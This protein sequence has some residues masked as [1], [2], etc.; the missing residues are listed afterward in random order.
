MRIENFRA[1]EASFFRRLVLAAP[2]IIW[3]IQCSLLALSGEDVVLSSALILSWCASVVFAI[4]ALMTSV[5]VIDKPTTSL[6]RTDTIA[7]GVAFLLTSLATMA[8]LYCAFEIYNE[9]GVPLILLP[10][11]ENIR[12]Q[13][14]PINKYANFL[15]SFWFIALPMCMLLRRSQSMVTLI[16]AV[17]VYSVFIG[18]RGA[19]LYLIFAVACYFRFSALRIM[20]I[21]VLGLMLILAKAF[22]LDVTIIEYGAILLS[23]Q[24]EI[25]NRYTYEINELYLGWF[26]IIRPFMALVPGDHISLIDLQWQLL[27]ERFD[28]LLV[29]SINVYSFLDFGLLGVIVIQFIYL[30]LGIFFMKRIRVLPCTSML[31]LFC[32]VISFYDSLLNKLFFLILIGLAFLLD[33]FVLRRVRRWAP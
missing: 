15:Q 27:G 5:K 22:Q 28:G 32:Y 11:G 25:F 14:L 10:D 18:Q 33:T 6:P 12:L 13:A 26:S 19:I 31:I 4:V 8:S 17:L 2:W 30:F 9:F 21:L 7:L 24:A 16:L 3:S 29:G 23:S 1:F 20:P